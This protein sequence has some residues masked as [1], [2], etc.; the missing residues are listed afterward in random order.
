[1]VPTHRVP[2]ILRARAIGDHEYLRE[3]EQTRTTPETLPLIAF[4][5]VERL[6]QTHATPF[7]LDMHQRQAIHEKSHVIT[8]LVDARI[9][10][11]LVHH[12]QPVPVDMLTV[13]QVDV[14]DRTIIP[15][16]RDHRIILDTPGLVDDRQRR[17][18]NV[19]RAE[20]FPLGVGELDAVQLLEL[21]PQI[22]DEL[23]LSLNVEPVVPLTCQ[24][25]DQLALEHGLGLVG[26]LRGGN[27]GSLRTHRGLRPLQDQAICRNPR[28]SVRRDGI[29]NGHESTSLRGKSSKRSR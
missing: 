27:R 14:L 26:L 5:L 4:D 28:S 7:Q 16:E 21:A 23:G 11:V 2:V 8:V 29:I 3:L 24:N 22:G 1:M 12:L 17:V 19:L 18:R 13:Q 6:P 9:R 15:L 10:L 25:R 20:P